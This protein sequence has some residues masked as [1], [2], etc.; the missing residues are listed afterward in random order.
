VPSVR[1]DVD[2]TGEPVHDVC[3]RLYVATRAQRDTDRS[4]RVAWDGYANFDVVYQW[5]FD[6]SI[7][8]KEGADDF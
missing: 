7:G 2:H 6:G 1:T 4:D 8:P 3:F 5:T